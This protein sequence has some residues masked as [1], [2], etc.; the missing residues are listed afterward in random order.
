MVLSFNCSSPEP[1]E[2]P[3]LKM[4]VDLTNAPQGVFHADLEIPCNAGGLTLMYPKWIP[5]EHAPFGPVAQLSEVTFHAPGKDISWQ[6]DPDDMYTFHC[7]VPEN[8]TV[9]QASLDY[10]SPTTIDRLRIRVFAEQHRAS[11]LRFSG[12][13]FCS[14]RR[15]ESTDNVMCEA[16]AAVPAGLENRHLPPRTGPGKRY[17]RHSNPV[18][19]TRL[20]DSPVMGG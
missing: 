15:A 6:R 19:L 9:L 4:R 10:L 14:I 17:G 7:T 18:S 1:A 2:P 5:G 8:V 20:V 13:T 16:I 12:I 11:R 3:H